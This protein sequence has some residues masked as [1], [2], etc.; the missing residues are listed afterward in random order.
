[1][2]HSRYYSLTRARHH[3]LVA[4]VS[5]VIT[6]ACG[7]VETVVVQDV[8]LRNWDLDDGLLST[9]ISAIARTADG[10][11]WVPTLHGVARFDG[12]RFAIFNSDNVPAFK[13]NDVTALLVDRSDT[14][15]VGTSRGSLLKRAGDG[16]AA[17]DLA[18]ADRGAKVT[19]LAQDAQGAIWVGTADGDIIRLDRGRS[20]VFGKADGLDSRPISKLLYGADGR[21]WAV[22]GGRLLVFADGRWE[23]AGGSKPDRTVHTIAP[24]RD[25]TLWVATLAGPA[26]DNSGARIFKL[27]ADDW[28]AQ[29]EPYP[30][31]QDSLRSRIWA[32]VEDK[33]GRLWC[34]SD[35]RGVY[36][37]SAA[38]G[39]QLLAAGQ[40][41]S[42]LET[43]CLAEDEEGVIW[44][45]TRTAGLHQ[46]RPRL[47]T[48]YRLPDE[49]NESTLVTAC[50]ARDGSVWGGTDGAGIFRWHGS[51]VSRFGPESGLTNLRVASLLEDRN[52]NLWAGTEAGVFRMKGEH[53][54]PVT[55]PTALGAATFAL[56]EDSRGRL[57]AG[58][59]NKVVCLDGSQAT[60]FGRGQ[61][62][63]AGSVRALDEDPDGRLWVAVAGSG[64]Y[65]QE[66]ERF[67]RYE[68]RAWSDGRPVLEWRGWDLIRALH[69]D[70]DGVLW[71]ATGGFGLYR[72]K[73]GMLQ[74]WEWRL[75][76]L[77]SSHLFALLED[78]RANLWLS[79]ENGVFGLS[80]KA[81][82][83]YRRGES[84]L[85]AA[86]RLTPANGLPFKVC[87]GMGQPTAA[88]SSDGRLVFPDG[89][90]LA[91]FEPSRVA[92]G[93]K[94]WPALVES[95]RVDGV[96]TRVTA[97]GLRIKSGMRQ[98]DL[99]YTSPSMVLAEQLRFRVRMNGLDKDWVDAGTRRDISYYRLPPGGYEF[100]VAV[101]GP[102][103]EWRE[104]PGTPF[105][106]VPR[107]WERR[108]LQIPGGLALLASAGGVVW[109]VERSRSRRRMERLELQRKLERERARIAKDLHDDLGASLTQIALLSELAQSDF[110]QPAKA[111]GHLDNV[112]RTA[113]SLTRSLDEIVWAVNPKNDT[114]D[115]FVVNLC[116]F[117]QGFLRTA[118]IRCRLDVPLELPDEPL[119]AALRHHLY[120]AVKEALH[121]VIKHSGASEVWLRLT[122]TSEWLTFVVEDN[123]QG[124][125]PATPGAEGDGLMN[126][127]Q[128]MKELGGRFE[129]QSQPGRGTTNRFVVPFKSKSGAAQ[130]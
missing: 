127:H 15:L 81:L 61:G 53:F 31:P 43:L 95:V 41:L 125:R 94:I 114:L 72:L 28:E 16:F 93:A 62:L 40:P 64:L 121:N 21:L 11:L 12:V 108:S 45:G 82:S 66:G 84:P 102:A 24:S 83:E 104:G 117:A 27:R 75:D 119:P 113:R 37:W 32:L 54:E 97:A 17:V 73:D 87:S 5:V 50:A 36:L 90:A 23:L 96:A 60:V 109:G 2:A 118:G 112:F 44:I 3:L 103:G 33:E 70:G 129:Q 1:M 48:S 128:R 106:I 35:G 10:Y 26:S 34:G 116:N 85:L 67:E 80:K 25:G 79:S 14:L 124:F 42:Q 22:T 107:F 74:Q 4:A 92:R 8:V 86:W 52:T 65:R 105:E 88:R 91:E 30:W 110:D 55:E 56:M 18:G 9:R 7:A 59:R 20:K 111:K 71:L 99:Q 49:W 57:W 101:R 122:L 47:V 13:R 77:P 115:R 19:A 89:P 63:P 120:F 39:W 130:I 46:A 38:G 123:G 51:A 78:D 6:A 58:G 68:P 76:G 69:W 126:L 98:L 100:R 29:L